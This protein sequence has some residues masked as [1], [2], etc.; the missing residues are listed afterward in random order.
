[1]PLLVMTK[2]LYA[3]SYALKIYEGEWNFGICAIS[4]PSRRKAAC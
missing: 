4:L 2:T 1:M 3:S